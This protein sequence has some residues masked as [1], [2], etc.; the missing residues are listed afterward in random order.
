MTQ[1]QL[2][3]HLMYTDFM[4]IRTKVK[5]FKKQKRKKNEKI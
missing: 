5:E 2:Y 3:N 1:R 4:S